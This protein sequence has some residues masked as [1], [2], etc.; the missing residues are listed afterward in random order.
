MANKLF[1]VDGSNLLFQ[2]FYGMPSRII[3]KSGKPIHGTIGFMGALLKMIRMVNPT[4]MLILF[5]GE[6]RNPR[7]DIDCDYKA[8]RPDFSA[9]QEEETPFCQ[10]PDI[11]NCLEYLGIRYMETSDCETDD[12]IATY[13]LSLGNQIDMVIS[14][15]DSDF[16]Q[17]I[18]DRVTILRYRGDS[19]VMCTPQYVEMKLGIAPSLYAD[20]KCLVGDSADNIKGVRGIGP[21]TAQSLINR[22]GCLENILSSTQQIENIR[23]RCAIEESLERLKTN[24]SLIKLEP[25]I[26]LPY[27]LEQLCYAPKGVTST[28]VMRHLN[29]I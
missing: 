28:Q 27:V 25:T 10:L 22:F 18:T 1:L 7:K 3:G 2:M 24:Y 20:Y 23:M 16:F 4:H 15:F 11:F 9:M 14:S 19:S 6:T 13:A 8:N 29:I 17:L 26:R 12:V 21:K 5:D